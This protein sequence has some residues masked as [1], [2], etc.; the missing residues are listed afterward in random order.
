MARENKGCGGDGSRPGFPQA[1]KTGEKVAVFPD[2]LPLLPKPRDRSSA[3]AA[4]FAM[5]FHAFLSPYDD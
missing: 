5:V 2:P 1:L 4:G 3:V